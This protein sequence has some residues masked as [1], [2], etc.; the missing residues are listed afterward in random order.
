MRQIDRNQLLE[1]GDE[2][3]HTLG[4][5]IELEQLDSDETVLFLVIRAKN[6]AEHAGANL[7]ENAEWSESVRVRRAGSVRVQCG[8]SSREGE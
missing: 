4:R 6:G 7:M 8:Y 3:M 2:L 5:Q 1:I